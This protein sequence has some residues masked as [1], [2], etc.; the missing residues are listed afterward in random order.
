MSDFDQ[1]S[2]D[3]SEYGDALSDL[4]FEFQDLG[5]PGGDQQ[6]VLPY[7]NDLGVDIPD[8]QE[9]QDFAA[10]L[11]AAANGD[12]KALPDV[13]VHLQIQAR[14]MGRRADQFRALAETLMEMM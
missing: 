11:L 7:L 9:G 5:A 4:E 3:I 6:I 2:M 13:L 14:K 1:L 12:A 8:G 10:Q